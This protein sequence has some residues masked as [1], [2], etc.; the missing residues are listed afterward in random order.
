MLS[1]PTFVIAIAFLL[2]LCVGCSKSSESRKDLIREETKRYN[3]MADIM[4]TIT[5]RASFEAAKS[6]LKPYL[7]A[8]LERQKKLREQEKQMSPAEKEKAAKEEERN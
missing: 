3:Q 7:V 5:D 6:K 2:C 8:R 1:R 4:S